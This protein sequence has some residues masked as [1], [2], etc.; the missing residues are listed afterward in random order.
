[1]AADEVAA[2]LTVLL[3]GGWLDRGALVAVERSTRSGP[4][5]WPA[6]YAEDRSRRYGEATLWYGLATSAL[7]A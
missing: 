4:V 5:P 1:M 7:L 2:M 3:D 6:G